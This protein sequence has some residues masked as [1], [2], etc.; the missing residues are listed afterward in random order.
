ML[1]LLS[2]PSAAAQ[3]A[4]ALSPGQGLGP[5]G[6]RETL[7]AVDRER[8]EL[9]RE[10]ASAGTDS[11][12]AALLDAAGQLLRRAAVAAVVPHWLGTRWDF[13]GTTQIPGQGAI[14][15]G[16]F[17]T[18]LLRDLGV[19]LDRIGLAQEPAERIIRALVA[20]AQISRFSDTPHER[21]LA[22]L[23]RQGDGLYLVGLDIHVGFIVQEGET[24]HFIH[25]SYGEPR[26]VVVEEASA[27]PILAGSRYRVLGKLSGDG[28]FLR[29]WLGVELAP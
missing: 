4:D 15:C 23:R 13:N 2:T 25:S 10:Y 18:T 29:S 3:G 17:V 27:A 5:V 24:V 7:A 11:A 12:R 6:Y 1:C 14:A 26:C 8:L 19:A 20:P 9:A 22:A 16:Y 28:H 21:L